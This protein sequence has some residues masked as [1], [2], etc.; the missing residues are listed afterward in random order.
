MADI[1]AAVRARALS[2]HEAEPSPGSVVV[3]RACE[4]SAPL[5]VAVRDSSGAWLFDCRLD[6]GPWE[7]VRAQLI[8]MGASVLVID[9][10]SPAAPAD[11]DVE[12]ALALSAAASPGPWEPYFTVHGDPFVVPSARPWPSSQIAA[13][14][15]SPSDYG[16]ADAVFVAGARHLVPELAEEVARLRGELRGLRVRQANE[17][18]QGFLDLGSDDQRY[19]I[20]SEPDLLD[21]L[22]AVL[23]VRP[24]DRA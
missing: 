20:E 24:R 12:A 13:V 4:P 15:T 23:G 10:A 1:P 19:L 8:G 9:P 3:F 5:S 7:H 11:P 6:W 2:F 14:S 17:A 18:L 16:R 21:Q 22:R